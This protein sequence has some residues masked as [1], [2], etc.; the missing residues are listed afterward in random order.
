MNVAARARGKRR[1]AVQFERG[2]VMGLHHRILTYR[3]FSS[4]DQLMNLVSCP[5]GRA[6]DAIKLVEDGS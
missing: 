3:G 1:D 6:I 5:I 4:R 2:I